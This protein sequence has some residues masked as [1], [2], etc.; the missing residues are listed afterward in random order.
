MKLSIVAYEFQKYFYVE[1]ATTANINTIYISCRFI[2]SN[3]PTP[4]QFEAPR[5]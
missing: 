3:G 4:I 2:A 1:I 5:K